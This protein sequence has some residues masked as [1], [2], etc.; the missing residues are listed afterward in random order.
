MKVFEEFLS[1]KFWAQAL[2]R[3]APFF[4]VFLICMP[5]ETHD[6][7]TMQ[8]IATGL[9]EGENLTK[10]ER[11]KACK[12]SKSCR[13]LAEVGYYEA[14]N[15]K[16]D[17][18][19]AGPMFVVL[20]RVKSP[21]WGNTLRSVVYQP[22][23][24]SYTHDGSMKKGFTDRKS[25]ERMLVLAHKVWVGDMKDPTQGATH[26][27]TTSITIGWASKLRK[28]AAL[29]DHIYYKKESKNASRKA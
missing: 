4:I 19:A 22:K 15:Q 16:S 1:S 27:H 5:V 25:H 10:E 23:Q 12:K 21:W 17:K 7:V 28:V 2:G 29:G 14:R 3:L 13:L 9:V 24:F 6:R 26:Y 8:H 11:V 18:A 20:N